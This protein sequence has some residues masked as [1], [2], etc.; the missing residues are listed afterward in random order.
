MKKSRGL[1]KI[2]IDS[3]TLVK[4]HCLAVWIILHETTLKKYV[5]Q[6]FLYAHLYY[7]QI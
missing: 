7:M 4:M 3:I 1:W 2:C 5:E 6:E